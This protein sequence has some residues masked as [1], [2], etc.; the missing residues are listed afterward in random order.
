MLKTQVVG[1]AADGFP[2][3]FRNRSSIVMYATGLLVLA[4]GFECYGIVGGADRGSLGEVG[5]V[6]GVGVA[7]GVGGAL[8]AI[9]A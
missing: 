8:L 3:D 5:G 2:V 7:G 9:S 4:H 1:A 6:G